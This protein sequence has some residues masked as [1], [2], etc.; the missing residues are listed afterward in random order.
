MPSY[1]VIGDN[2]N[3]A[4]KAKSILI[5]DNSNIA[6]KVKNIYIGD[7]DGKAQQAYRGIYTTTVTYYT[8]AIEPGNMSS[9]TALTRSSTSGTRAD[10]E[11]TPGWYFSNNSVNANN[12]SYTSVNY[13]ETTLSVNGIQTG[14]YTVDSRG[15]L[16]INCRTVT[17]TRL[18]TT[19]GTN[20]QS[21]TGSTT[22]T[23]RY[24][25]SISYNS[26]RTSILTDPNLT[27]TALYPK[28]L[29]EIFTSN[30]NKTTY[31]FSSSPII[32][33]TT[34]NQSWTSVQYFNLIY[35]NNDKSYTTYITYSYTGT[36]KQNVFT[37]QTLIFGKTA[38]ISSCYAYYYAYTMTGQSYQ[39]GAFN[40]TIFTTSSYFDSVQTWTIN[41]YKTSSSVS[42][43]S[44]SNYTSY[45]GAKNSITVQASTL[46]SMISS[47]TQSNRS[48]TSAVTSCITAITIT[49]SS[50]VTTYNLT[51]SS[52]SGYSGVSSSTLTSE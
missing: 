14:S 46:Y 9:T 27:N 37:A 42:N 19:S 40:S 25:G 28:I 8:S 17:F 44:R 12:V 49:S 5:G 43:G 34:F 32:V 2:N 22:G 16:R 45:E 33:T 18:S 29:S 23:T 41:T 20:G 48:S 52:T 51:C 36:T 21:A 10:N 3:I 1:I 39:N 24:A 35:Y 4:Q 26:D 31:I 47:A 15:Y 30:T 7:T 13:Y 50:K 38:T 6:H 11:T